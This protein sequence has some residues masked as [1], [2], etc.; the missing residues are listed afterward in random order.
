MSLMVR[1]LVQPNRVFDLLS[2]AS[3]SPAAVFVRFALVLG[4]LPPL[5]A[6]IGASR[7]GW[8]LGAV[9]PLSLPNGILV[10]ISIAYFAT[11]L[12][13]FLSSAIVSQWMAGTYGARQELG[14][15]FALMT[16]IGAPLAVGSIVHLY[17]DAFI[18]MVVLV[19]VLIWSMTLL[20]RGLPVVL[21]TGPERGMLMASAR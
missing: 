6:Y 21:H 8:R 7:F 3:P 15:H 20:Y 2:Q 11:L 17:P 1:A 4:V 14:V 5:F 13:G 9:E 10:M 16:I 19:P 18:N 12:F